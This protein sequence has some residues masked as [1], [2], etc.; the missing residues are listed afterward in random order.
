MPC[1]GPTTEAGKAAFSRNAVKHGLL[2]ESPVVTALETYDDWQSHR[3]G[4]LADLAPRGQMETCLA[5]RAA[6]L[7]WRLRRTAEAEIHWLNDQDRDAAEQKRHR[8]RIPGFDQINCLTRY[9]AHLG[10]ELARAMKALKDLQSRP[11]GDP[12]RH[13]TPDTRHPARTLNGSTPLAFDNPDTAL[14]GGTTENYQTNSTPAEGCS[15]TPLLQH[16]TTPA[17]GASSG[18]TEPAP[19]CDPENCETNPASSREPSGTPILQHSI[20]PTGQNSPPRKAHESETAE[21][22]SVPAPAGFYWSFER[23]CFRPLPS[24]PREA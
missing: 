18:S 4:V 17:E 7:I 9:E 10:R 20:T 21:S 6:L 1:T 23:R 14:T 3:D 11:A 16:S 15:E 2:S 13:P 12:T 5:E 19:A 24:K 8:S 22:R